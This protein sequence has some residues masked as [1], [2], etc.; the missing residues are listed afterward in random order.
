MVPRNQNPMTPRAEILMEWLDNLKEVLTDQ[1]YLKMSNQCKHI[2]E[3]QKLQK[4]C[5]STP[6]HNR[7]RRR[8]RRHCL[9]ILDRQNT[10]DWFL[11]KC[12]TLSAYVDNVEKKGISGRTPLELDQRPPH[13]IQKEIDVCMQQ[14]N[15]LLDEFYRDV[16]SGYLKA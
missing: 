5:K 11:F 9:R 16:T 12:T 6:I 14:C 13:E 10:I 1:T 7:E 3:R 8:T 2:F 4:R 15:D